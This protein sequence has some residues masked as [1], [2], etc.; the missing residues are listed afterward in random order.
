MALTVALAGCNNQEINSENMVLKYPKTSKDTSVQDDFYGTVVPDP[1]RWL[2]NDTALETKDWIEAQNKLTFDHLAEIPYRKKLEKRI[3]ELWNYEKVSAPFRRGDWLYF[4]KNDGL[5]NHSVLYRQKALEAEAEVFLDP[6]N[7]SEDGTTSLSGVSFSKDGSLAAYQISEGGSDWRKVVVI[8]TD[9]K[10]QI[11]DTLENIKFSGL[12]WRG[13][14]GFYYSS[15][16]MPTGSRLSAKTDDHRLYFHGLAQTQSEDNVI[17]GGGDLK[18]RYVGGRVTEDQKWLIISAAEST[19]GNEIYIKSLEKE[20]API[21]PVVTGYDHDHRV[22]YHHQGRLYIETN[23]GA[24]NNR[25]VVADTKTPEAGNWRDLIPE[26]KDV[27]SASTAGGKLYAHYMVDAISRVFQYDLEGERETEIELPGPGTASGFGGRQE[28]TVL[29]YNFTSYIYPGTTFK[30]DIQKMESSLYRASAAD[31]DPEVYVSEQVIYQSKD[32]TEIPMIITH[33]KGVERNGANPTM[34]YGYG[35]FNVSLTPAF[36][37]ARA[38]WLEQG[39]V[40]AV[41][42]LRGGGEYGED[43]HQA[44]MKMNKQNVFDDFI[45]AAEY[46]IDEGYTQSEKLAIAGGSN[47]GLLVGACMIQRPDLF[48]VALPAVGVLDMLRYHKFTAGAGWHT[49]YGTADESEE[50]FRYLYGYSPYHNLERGEKYPATLITTGDH[51]DRVVP[52]HSFKFTARLQEVQ[53]GEAP[54][55]IRIETRAGHG[56]GKPTSMVIEEIADKYAFSFYHLGYEE[57]LPVEKASL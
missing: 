13:K 2:E 49:D 42:N 1:Y 10:D 35:G 23:R 6:N 57:Q 18:R 26:T 11:G 28:D 51:D 7:F 52:A 14:E 4:Y 32:G 55:L 41:P 30:Y 37:I 20:D 3:T 25:V 40:Y 56:A 12:S 54:V 16:N 17:F 5:Q 15:Y 21:I 29:Y 33:K 53:G 31:F 46:L 39:G 36:S 27:L 44:G 8:S 47:G 43:W 45:A 22:L 24:P 9:T 19:T 50:M 48:A 38:A 34:L